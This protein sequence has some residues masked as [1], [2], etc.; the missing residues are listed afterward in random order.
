MHVSS[1]YLFWQ[2]FCSSTSLGICGQCFLSADWWLTA[3]GMTQ[4]M[5][6]VEGKAKAK[7]VAG[8]S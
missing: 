1:L 3:V 5:H 7:L 2:F 4:H 6:G 8:L